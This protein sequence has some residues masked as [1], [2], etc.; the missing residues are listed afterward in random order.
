MVLAFIFSIF[1][2][3]QRDNLMDLCLMEI[4]NE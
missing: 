3:Y 2:S 4:L 1:L